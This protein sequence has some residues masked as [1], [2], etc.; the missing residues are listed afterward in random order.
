MKKIV[1]FCIVSFG[2]TFKLFAQLLEVDSLK[3][4]VLMETNDSEK[5]RTLNKFTLLIREKDT[6]QGLK[7][8]IQAEELALQLGDSL[9]LGRAKGNLGWIYYR[10]GIWDKAFKYSKDAYLIGMQ[11]NDKLEIGMALNNLGALYYQRKNF[12]EAIKNFREAYEIALEIDDHF[13][14]I[15]SLNNLALNFSKVGELDSALYFANTALE[16]NEKEGLMYFTSFT[17]RVIGDVF[18]AKNELDTAIQIYESALGVASHQRLKTYEASIFHRLGKAYFLSGNIPKALEYLERGIKI[19]EQNGFQEELVSTYQVLATV[20]HSMGDITRA[21]QYHKAFSELKDSM[22]EQIDEDRMSLLQAMFEVEKSDAEIN[23]LKIENSLKEL[24]IRSV[25]RTVFVASGFVVLCLFLLTWLY[26][27]NKKLKNAND[28]LTHKKAITELQ[29]KELESKSQELYES[30]KMKNRLLSILGHDLKSPVAQ[31]KGVLDLMHSQ[32]LTKEE[33][34]GVSHILKRNVDGL[35]ETM[36]NILSWSK[37]QME[38]FN[39][40]LS[41]TNLG[42][43][44]RPCLDLLQHQAISKEITINLNIGHEEKALVDKDLLQIVVRN[45]VSNAIKFSNK[46]SKIDIYTISEDEF[47]KLVVQD[48]GLGMSEIQLKTI[49]NDQVS[50]LESSAGTEKEKGTG[51]GLNLCKEFLN[52]MGGKLI[53]TS[54]KGEGTT[55]I[56]HLQRIIIQQEKALV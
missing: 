36:D 43:V 29:K 31:L 12:L 24:E 55:A 14:T 17:N 5:L 34:E 15:R 37:S 23:Y 11:S 21:Y 45:L 8:G 44:I 2:I 19:S 56:V 27:F 38:G 4:V 48:F 49:L 30:N 39:V 50:L 10:L 18:L 28:R 6:Q 35:F 46:G 51:L 22:E 25:R 7:W 41:P 52:L 42:K 47:L 1:L 32:G 20:Y 3:K 53:I 9:E 13:L 16:V 40:Q 26:I 33:F 54:K